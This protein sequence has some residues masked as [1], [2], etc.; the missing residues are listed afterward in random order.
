MKNRFFKGFVSVLLS[1]MITI[2]CLAAYS[3]STAA[4]EV[5]KAETST[6]QYGLLD[7]VENGL[8]LHC[9]CWNFNTIKDNMS[10]IAE[11]GYTAVQTSPINKVVVGEGGGM[12][13]RGNGKW[14]YHYQP[15]AY[16]IGNYQLGT[17]AEFKAMCST[18]HSY[19]VK[20]IV[21]VV[22]NHTTSNTGA[23]DDSIKNISGGA[24]HNISGEINYSSRYDVTQKDLLGLKDL[25]TQ[26]QNVANL[27]Q[28]YLKSCV[29]AGADGFRYDAA[30]HIGLP[31][32]PK[33]NGRKNNFW[34][35]VTSEITDADRIFNYGEV[36]QGSNDRISDYIDTIGACTASSYGGYI[37]QGI[38]STSISS[39]KISDLRVGSSSNCVTWVESHDNY[40]NDGNW[41][42]MDDNQV[43]L[44]YAI[45]AARD[46]GTPLFFDRPMGNSVENQWGTENRIGTNG[47]LFYK[48]DVVRAVNFFRNAMVGEENDFID[49]DENGTALEICRG[50]KGAVI[51]NT[52]FDLKGKFKTD[53]PDGTYVNRV[54]NKTEYTVKGGK[55]ICDKPI[56]AESV[57]VLYNDNYADNYAPATVKFDDG[58]QFVTDGDFSAKLVSE[59]SVKST[60]KVNDGEE[61]EFK[62][63]DSVTV[64]ADEMSKSTATVE[65][66]GE[67]DKG[68]HS[69]VKY[70][71]TNKKAMF[72]G[73]GAK[74]GDTITF[75]KPDSW[76]N[77]INAYI[78]YGDNQEAAWPG[79]A[80]TKKDGNTYTYELQN[81]W[82]MGY[83]IF[84]DGTEQYPGQNEQGLDLESGGKYSVD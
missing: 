32:D 40:I 61:K 16:T 83:V 50:K 26:N 33:E 24:Y 69:Y 14:Y 3:V 2:S 1:V 12:Q 59:N 37:R 72:E 23:V 13:L 28:S 18:A 4:S 60:Y 35:R 25:N 43:L 41:S 36:L 57:V 22:A 81:D 5:T 67:N 42:Q 45:I 44:G 78:Y 77:S 79:N 9:F 53:L 47:D 68:V 19:G 51:I 66:F 38:T 29:A 74:K 82:D 75:T 11:A 48:N 65:L 55:L 64:K 30:K 7:N 71:I 17:E 84:N 62:N 8:I 54:D 34:T 80:M 70:I 63:G 46:G 15:T 56:P 20:V 21:D 39:A 58:A 52:A 6:N 49:L 10:K 31:D 73:K 27:I 76:G